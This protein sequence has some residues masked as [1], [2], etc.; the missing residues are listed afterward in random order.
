MRFGC[1]KH[2]PSDLAKASQAPTQR[3]ANEVGLGPCK[4]QYEASKVRAGGKILEL[5]SIPLR[6]KRLHE[7]P[8]SRKPCTIRLV[9]RLA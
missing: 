1:I 5:R 9:V 7:A 8:S 3:V 6:S 2:A 4:D